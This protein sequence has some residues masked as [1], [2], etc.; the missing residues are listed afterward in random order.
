MAI[1]DLVEW[2][3][4]RVSHQLL[5]REAWEFRDNVTAYDSLYLAAARLYRAP[6]LTA[7]G[8]LARIPPTGVLIE[9]V[10]A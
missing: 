5:V 8:P 1:T 6:V 9:N 4:R 7:D 3:L 2:P 10:R